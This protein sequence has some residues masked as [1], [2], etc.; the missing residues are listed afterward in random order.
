MS[1]SA[2]KAH[3]WFVEISGTPAAVAAGIPVTTGELAQMD[4]C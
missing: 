2:V 3:S 4:G 1:C